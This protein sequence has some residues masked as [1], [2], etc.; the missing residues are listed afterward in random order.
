M[1]IPMQVHSAGDSRH[2][3]LAAIATAGLALLGQGTAL[4]AEDAQG[5]KPR[6][7]IG[8]GGGVLQKAYRDID[9]KTIGIPLLIYEGR[10][11]S[12]TGPGLSFKFPDAGAFSFALT[13]QLSRDGYE[14]SDSP[15]LAGMDERKD[16]VWVGASAKWHTEIADFAA[17]WQ[18][19][20]SD[21]SGGQKFSLSAQRRF[22]A[23]RFDFTPRLAATWLDASYVDYYY[24]VQA[25]EVRLARPLYTPGSTVNFE[26]GLRTGFR[27]RERDSLFLDLGVERLGSAIEDSPLVEKSSESRVFMGYVHLF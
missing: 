14:D 9:S 18:T 13:A 3:T 10:W 22:S 11:I 5:G 25:H 12:L 27:L 6:W 7:G 20:A 15:F 16:N 21:Y 19:D 23:G 17:H 8:L 24:G 2:R 1:T 4:A 26:A